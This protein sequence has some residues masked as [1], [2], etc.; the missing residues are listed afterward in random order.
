[1]PEVELYDNLAEAYDLLISWKRRLRR[2]RP[3]FI[4]I[5]KEFGVKRILDTACGTGMHAIAFHD[6]GYYVIGTDI[7]GNMVEKSKENAGNRNI[8]FIQAGFTEMEKVGGMFDAVTCLGNSLPHVLTDEGLDESLK[9]MFDVLVPGGIVVIHSNNYDRILALRERFMPLARGVKDGREY[10]FM[11][12]FDF[13]ENGLL[14]FNVVT[15]LKKAGEWQM[16]PDASTHRPITRDLLTGRLEKAGY[17]NINVYG[18]YPDQPFNPLESDN[19]IV[20]AQKPHTIVSKPRPEPVSAIDRIPIRDT[21]EQILNI[22]ETAPEIMVRD[23]PMFARETII[24][25]LQKAQSLLPE[26]HRLIMKTACRSLEYQRTMYTGFYQSLKEQHPDWPASQLRRETNKFL[27]PPDAKHPP[28]HTTGGA[29]DVSII[30]PDGQEL[31]MV[32]T[33]K[34]DEDVMS[35]L[36]TYTKKVSPRV[37]KNRQILIDAM[38]AAGFSNYPGEWW[39]WSYGDSAWA[40]RVGAPN[41]FYGAVDYCTRTS[42]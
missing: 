17:V 22:S 38:S 30:G 31:D 36:Y 1:M 35:T 14:T 27:A 12:F 3:F 11:R 32:S 41:A 26:G 6:W 39:H 16:F 7:S 18:G 33:I 25:M 28:G 4:R 13:H 5:F 24:R 21:G 34:G 23:E 15:M 8:E 20:V 29:V 10:L 19:L 42:E 9:S 2:E 40:V 37:A